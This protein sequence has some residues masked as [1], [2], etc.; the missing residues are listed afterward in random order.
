MA[1]SMTTFDSIL[2]VYYDK[3]VIPQLNQAF[4]LIARMKKSSSDWSGKNCTVPC[5][6][7]RNGGRGNISSGGAMPASGN[8]SYVELILNAKLSAQKISISR[9]AK[10]AA[11]LGQKNY[12]L[13]YIQAEVDPA[14]DDMAAMA[15]QNSIF[16]GL[17]KGFLNEHKVEAVTT[18]NDAGGVDE[19][20]WEW[21]GLPL[22]LDYIDGNPFAAFTDVSGAAVAA[23]TPLAA[24]EATWRRVR[25]FRGD[26]YA[27]IHPETAA[28]VAGTALTAAVFVTGTSAGT[29][30]V[31]LG[32]VVN[33]GTNRRINTLNPAGSAMAP[34]VA[35]FV[36]VHTVNFRN[37]AGAANI[38]RL[39]SDRSGGRSTLGLAITATSGANSTTVLQQ[40]GVYSQLASQTH[41]LQDRTTAT[42]QAALQSNLLTVATTG[43]HQRQPLTKDSIQRCLDTT[44]QVSGKE[45]QVAYISPRDRQILHGLVYDEMRNKGGEK[46]NAGYKGFAFGTVEEWIADQHVG[47]SQIILL[48]FKDDVWGLF[49]YGDADMVRDGKGNSIFPSM[50]VSADEMAVEWEYDILCKR[51]N[52]QC[53]LLGYAL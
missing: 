9:D 14:M 35:V 46:T 50:D 22:S 43:N 15:N 31:S 19:S 25:L 24:N 3:K 28:G 52:S 23:A 30:E 32:C 40:T 26:T 17:C 20:T 8:Q 34:G 11:R 5:H 44:L 2:K 39:D 16:G 10:K 33:D 27:E 29:T 1:A 41:F 38:G 36:E 37:A 13:N 6:V 48:D 7:G 21:S 45:P 51:P 53:L 42:G 12:F 47:R 49:Q 4:T 18:A